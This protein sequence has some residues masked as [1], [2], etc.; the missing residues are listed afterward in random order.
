MRVYTYRFAP[1]T[2]SIVAALVY[3]LYSL[4]RGE[5]E[6]DAAIRQSFLSMVVDVGAIGVGFIAAM[7]GIVAGLDGNEA[8]RHLKDSNTY[9]NLVSYMYFSSMSCM[10]LVV[11]SLLIV[12]ASALKG[13]NTQA[14]PGTR[15]VLASL[16]VFVATY[17][18]TS[19]ARVIHFFSAALLYTESQPD[20]MGS[21]PTK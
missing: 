16:W 8:I 6:M 21:D 2:I 18:V 10:A 7:M 13:L 9:K 1:V 14:C 15:T 3:L 12:G 5:P 17:S 4:F 20:Q 19:C 11:Y